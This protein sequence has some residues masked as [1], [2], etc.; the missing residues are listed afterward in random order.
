MGLQDRDPPQQNSTY[1]GGKEREPLGNELPRASGFVF[2]HFFSPLCFFLLSFLHKSPICL[3]DNNI[4]KESFHQITILGRIKMTNIFLWQNEGRMRGKQCINVSLVWFYFSITFPPVIAY[5][6][7]RETYL[8]N[9]HSSQL[10]LTEVHSES[11]KES[12][13]GS[14]SCREWVGLGS[15][16]HKMG[17][18]AVEGRWYGRL[19]DLALCPVFAVH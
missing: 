9:P 4:E 13:W 2:P 12:S 5:Y 1:L 16:R 11:W 10:L 18:G 3:P 15:E 7:L 19:R 14:S 17:P 6:S 8:H